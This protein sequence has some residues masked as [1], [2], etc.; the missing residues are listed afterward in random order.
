[1]N[2]IMKTELIQEDKN[3]GENGGGAKIPQDV[4]LISGTVLENQERMVS[5][6]QCEICYTIYATWGD[7]KTA[8]ISV[9][10]HLKYNMAATR[11]C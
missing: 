4:S 3:W 8:P 10:Y 1:M 2:V 5:V 9:F 7:L 6:I 11:T